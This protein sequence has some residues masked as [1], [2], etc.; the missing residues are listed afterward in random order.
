MDD[1]RDTVQARAVQPLLSD[2]PVGAW[3]T[4]SDADFDL[5]EDA[6]TSPDAADWR[7]IALLQARIIRF[8]VDR[9]HREVRS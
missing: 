2:D 9:W 3:G 6:E 4:E 8:C 1:R 5:L 7:S